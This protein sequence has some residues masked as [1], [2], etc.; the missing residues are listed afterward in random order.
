MKNSSVAVLEKAVSLPGA[1]VTKTALLINPRATDKEIAELGAALVQIDGSRSFWLGDYGLFIQSRKRAEMKK[2]FPNVEPDTLSL[3]ATKYLKDKADALGI[4]SGTLSNY[5]GV[6][7]FFE[8]PNRN[9]NL[10]FAHHIVAKDAIG[11]GGDPLKAVKLMLKAEEENWSVSQF[12]MFVKTKGATSHA[13]ELEPMENE[14][15]PLDEADKWIQREVKEFDLSPEAARR[16]LTRFAN[17]IA[18]IEKL[19]ELAK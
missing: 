4:D 9:G 15:E 1:G 8:L 7:E 14:W 5:V 16:Q 6:C 19:K 12:R 13:P 18:F 10:S 3:N 11:A 17:I 2:Q